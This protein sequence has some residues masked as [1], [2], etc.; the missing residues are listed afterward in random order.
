[1]SKYKP[2]VVREAREYRGYRTNFQ[3]PEEDRPMMM[4]MRP[5]IVYDYQRYNENFYVQ[6]ANIEALNHADL[7]NNSQ[8]I[9]FARTLNIHDIGGIVK[10]VIPTVG[11]RSYMGNEY[12]LDDVTYDEFGNIETYVIHHPDI[13]LPLTIDKAK[14]INGWVNLDQIGG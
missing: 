13:R 7:H 8:Y 10:K 6:K 4:M 3:S 2:G 14:F 5:P 9:P 11:D 1:M 12:I